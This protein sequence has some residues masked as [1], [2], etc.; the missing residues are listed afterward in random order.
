MFS[1]ISTHQRQRNTS[2]RNSISN[3]AQGQQNFRAAARAMLENSPGQNAQRGNPPSQTRQMSPGLRDSISRL[4]AQASQGQNKS[5]AAQQDHFANSGR[6]HSSL[7]GL[8]SIDRSSARSSSRSSTS[9]DLG[10]IYSSDGASSQNSRMER[11]RSS[12]QR[13]QIYYTSNPICFSESSRSED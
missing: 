5:N 9:A 11:S 3:I 8:S 1:Q 2:A 4:Q 6:S 10:V 7:S 12:K 13:R